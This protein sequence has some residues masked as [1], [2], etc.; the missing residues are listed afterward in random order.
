MSVVCDHEKFY[1][2]KRK[3][4]Q[5]RRK[6]FS[7]LSIRYLDDF[8]DLNFIL[9]I[10]KIR[11]PLI[12]NASLLF[13]F[14]LCSISLVH[15][16]ILSNGWKLRCIRE[17]PKPDIIGQFWSFLVISLRLL[18]LKFFVKQWPWSYISS[19]SGHALGIWICGCSLIYKRELCVSKS[20]GAKG[21][22]SN[23]CGFMHPLHPC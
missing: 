14:I 16:M 20:A 7:A 13:L 17:W 3:P 6:S 10:H 2:S 15:C 1:N 21:D 9:H 23:I 4:Q 5:F 12:K 11:P 22:V 19:I 8:Q 18:P